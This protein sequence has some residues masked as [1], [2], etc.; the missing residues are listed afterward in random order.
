MS[1]SS[2]ILVVGG[3]GV[4]GKRM[5]AQLA[6]WYPG[7]VIVAGRNE[8]RAAAAC[9]DVRGGSS[10]RAIDVNDVASFGPALD[11]VGTLIACVAQ[12][13]LHLLRAC[14][15]RGVAYTDIA[16][17][18]AFWQ[19]AEELR[20]NAQKSGARILL[21]AGLCPG[22]SNMMVQKLADSLGHLDRIETAILLSLGDE[23]GPD[24]LHHVIE[25]AAQSYSVHEN[26]RLREGRLY[27][28]AHRPL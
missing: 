27:L 20:A 8:R 12:P 11:N 1:N 6:Q 4:V 19:G 16:P 14:I 21:G 5:A 9:L 25:A 10:S 7:R 2:Q 23:Y 15:A 28:L 17:R 24:S 26:G 3:Y 13:E 22:I 18:L